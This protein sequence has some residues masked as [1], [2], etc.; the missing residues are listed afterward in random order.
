MS[1]RCL[2]GDNIALGQRQMVA[3]QE[4]ILSGILELH[5]NQIGHLIVTWHISQPVICIQLFV[6]SSYSLYA[7]A[8]L[9]A[10]TY[11]FFHF[12]IS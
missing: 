1:W 7:Q 6:L 5:F 9:T 10:T 4:I 11:K 2:Y 12:I 3:V 8:S